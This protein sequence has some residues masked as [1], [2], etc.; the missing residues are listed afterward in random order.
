[1]K[2]SKYL[3]LAHMKQLEIIINFYYDCQDA[4]LTHWRFFP[5]LHESEKILAEIEDRTYRV[6]LNLTQKLCQGR[7]GKV[8]VATRG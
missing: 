7:A 2:N 5:I 8:L 3:W 1:M 4:Q 6:N